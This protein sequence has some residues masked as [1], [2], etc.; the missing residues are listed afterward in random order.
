MT[1][2][3]PSL[4]VEID[5]AAAAKK[6]ESVDAPVSGG[7]I[8]AKNATLSIMIGGKK[9]VVDALQPLFST[10]WERR[11]YIRGRLRGGTAHEDGEP[12]SDRHEHDRR[13]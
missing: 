12:D 5:Q 2:S 13:V 8:G 6:V 4:A 10:R 9:E 1:T 11:W 3:E 7:D